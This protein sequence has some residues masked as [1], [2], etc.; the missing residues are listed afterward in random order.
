MSIEL[1]SR[2]RVVILV[3]A[4]PR[5]GAKHGET[6]CCAGIDEN[7]HWV[8]LYPVI[9]R[10][11]DDAKKFGRWDIVEYD[12]KLP[13]G[14][15][16]S[17]S[18]RIEHTSL[19]IVSTLKQESKRQFLAKHVVSS[20]EGLIDSGKSLALLRPENPKFI[21]EKKKTDLFEQERDLFR[22]WHHRDVEGLFGHLSKDLVP[23]EPA[24]YAFRYQY[25]M[26][27]K[28]REGTC[29]DWEIEATYLRWSSRYGE[30]DTLQ[31][32]TQRFGVEYPKA[33]FVLAMGTHKAYPQWLINGI[34][35]LDHGAENEVQ[36]SL[37]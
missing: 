13:K 11:L 14:D 16:R 25:E 29:Q 17:E 9:F 23:Y 6:V 30:R 7:G 2:S 19:E 28:A 33:G 22:E 4:A 8:R 27:G 18:R 31:K 21:I 24:P 32:M 5:V 10:T 12:W 34:I 35:R 3:K 1:P 36:G 37:L 26:D 20:L 15:N